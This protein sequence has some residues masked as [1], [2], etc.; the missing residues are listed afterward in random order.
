MNTNL[1]ATLAGVAVVL[2]AVPASADTW[3]GAYGNTIN[4]TY[5]DGRTA[6]VY[7]EADHTYSIKLPN[8][9]VLKGRWADAGGQSCFT[10]TD[11]PQ[12]P[13]AKTPCFP[14]KEYKVG[15]TFSGEDSTG[16]FT[17]VIVAG[18]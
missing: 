7:V 2:A 10:L 11:P 15:D 17:S 3:S 1:V 13:G 8:G 12:A 9:T 6:K 16:K 5:T 4:A 18:R 14:V